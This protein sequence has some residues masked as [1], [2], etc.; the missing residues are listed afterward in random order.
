VQIHRSEHRASYTVLPNGL[1]RH[2][3]LSLAAVGLLSRLLSLPDG[4]TETISSL[5]KK[6][7]E[8]KRAISRAFSELAE[9]GYVLVHRSQEPRTGLWTTQVSVFDVPKAVSPK[10]TEP[11]PGQPGG[12]NPGSSTDVS[13]EGKYQGETL[14]TPPSVTEAQQDAVSAEGR[15]GDA[16]DINE[17]QGSEAGRAG[18]VLT[19]LALADR[20][21]RLSAE[22]IARLVPVAAEW[23]RRGVT[24][25]E[26]RAALLEGL[27]QEIA[28]P[29]GLL[30]DRLR[31]KM[32][33]ELI[34]AEP[35][36]PLVDCAACGHPLVRG[37]M[38]GICGPCA[39]TATP[40][41]MAVPDDRDWRNTASRPGVISPAH[42]RAL[43][44]GLVATS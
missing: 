39:G 21:L 32:P 34:P 9:A 33:A 17:R 23:L 19:S 1:L 7:R 27:P 12:R 13:T 41:P 3:D 2:P 4:T 24:E 15:A 44:R 10:G 6:V 5:A 28:V 22:D 31:R 37:Q 25:R 35:V 20:R 29:S 43:L 38:S 18:V 8:G 11:T 16:T 26:L 30:G 36:V 14:P 40:S 42:G